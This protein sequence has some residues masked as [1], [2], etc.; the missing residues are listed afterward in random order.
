MYV[1]RKYLNT[2]KNSPLAGTMA[3]C[4]DQ[5]NS[6]YIVTE[7][8][9][10]GLLCGDASRKHLV[11]DVV[12]NDWEEVT[13]SIP[14]P[15]DKKSYQAVRNYIYNHSREGLH[16]LY[17]EYGYDDNDL[18][19]IDIEFDGVKI[20]WETKFGKDEKYLNYKQWETDFLDRIAYNDSYQEYIE[21]YGAILYQAYRVFKVMRE[22]NLIYKG[23]ENGKC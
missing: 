5:I 6:G 21:F 16:S 10:D 2:N 13:C 18:A 8:S 20:L 19:N 17:E 14:V 12:A 9:G 3:K 7:Y 23:D 11:L 4:T 22:I 1:G 15:L